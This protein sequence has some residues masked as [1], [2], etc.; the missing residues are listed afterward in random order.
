MYEFQVYCMVPI[1]NG[2]EIKVHLESSTQMQLL[3]DFV[4][5]SAYLKVVFALEDVLSL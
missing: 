3:F 1:N 4:E 2:T 5:L